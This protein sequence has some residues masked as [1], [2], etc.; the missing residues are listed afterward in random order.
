MST[1]ERIAGAGLSA[2]RSARVAAESDVEWISAKEFR[3]LAEMTRQAASNILSACYQGQPWRG[4]YL[5]VRTANGKPPSQ[6]NPYQVRA[7]SLPLELFQRYMRMHPERFASPEIPKAMLDCQL[8]VITDA[9]LARHKKAVELAKWQEQL[10]A[11]ALATRKHSSDRTFAVAA[12]VKAGP[13]TRP[14]GTTVTPN[15]DTVERWIRKYEKHGLAGLMRQPRLA[16][17]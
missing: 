9:A 14:D 15:A 2:A 8:P 7:D 10:I 5:A 13:H 4:Y 16:A 1:L 11:P 12:V 3:E 6:R 17:P